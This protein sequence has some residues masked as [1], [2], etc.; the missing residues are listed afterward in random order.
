MSSELTIRVNFSRPIPLFPLDGVVLLPQQV[1]PLHIFEERY[2]QMTRHVLDAHGQIAMAVV[3]NP[4]SPG[5]TGPPLKRAVCIGQIEQHE[6]LPDGRFNILLRGVCRA[7]IEAEDPLSDDRQF[8]Q[9]YLEPIG[10][11]TAPLPETESFREWLQDELS[12]GPLSRLAVAEQIREFVVNDDVP[13]A[14]LLELV[15]FAVTSDTQLRYRLLE[16]GDINERARI[17]RDG[18][19]DLSDMIKQAMYQ[20][21]DDWPKGLSWN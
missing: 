2:R 12:G 16:E 9:A 1:M 20:R 3:E 7:R 10:L 5:P 21:P 6:A 11:D 8:R 19:Q 4:A 18:M 13:T 14:A 17:L 15:S